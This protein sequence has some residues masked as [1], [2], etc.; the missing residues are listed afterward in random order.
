[1]IWQVYLIISILLISCNGLFHRSLMK[2]DKSHPISQT[3][4]FLGLGGSIAIVIALLERKLQFSFPFS[5]TWNFVL[6]I[7]LS[8]PAY[9]LTY[10]AYQLLSASEV[11]LFLATGRIWNVVGAFFFLHEAITFTRV[12]GAVIILA[13][14]AITLYDKRKFAF[15]KGVVFIRFSLR[16]ERYQWQL[17]AANTQRD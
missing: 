13:G 15:N 6:L 17:Y 9:L 11:V 14:L 7:L 1:M 8:T 12:I 3:I 4:V 2:D 16:H 10:R 5:L